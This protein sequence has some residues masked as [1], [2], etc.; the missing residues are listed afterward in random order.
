[1]K[2]NKKTVAMVAGLVVL[3]VLGYGLYRATRPQ[4]GIINFQTVQ[5]KAKV[6]LAAAEQQKKYD[7]QIQAIILKDKDF[8]KLQ[9]EGKKLA[10]KQQTLSKAEFE[11]QSVVLQ[12]KALKINERYRASFERNAMASQIAL[13]ALEKDIAEDR[14]SVV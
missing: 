13:K 11:R 12:E 3:G 2:K 8:I 10:E 6:Y 1:M 14:K 5:Q 9:E 4:V 7:E